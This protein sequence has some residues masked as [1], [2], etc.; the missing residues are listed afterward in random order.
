[1]R[2]PVLLLDEPLAALDLK[3][4]QAMQ[5]ELRRIH[6]QIGGTFVFVTHD[7]GEA[8]SLANRIAV[9]EAGRIVQAGPPEEITGTR[10]RSSSRPSSARRT[11]FPACGAA[12]RSNCRS[13]CGFKMPARMR[14][15]SSS[16]VRR[17]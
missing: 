9:M 5:D 2:P 7:Q 16:C 1:M 10:A 4:R 11:F 17:R 15:S 13:A 12:G 3:L 8:M 6:A 14:R